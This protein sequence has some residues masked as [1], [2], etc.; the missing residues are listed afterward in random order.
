GCHSIYCAASEG[1]EEVVNLI[2]KFGGNPQLPRVGTDCTAAK[3]ARENGYSDLANR[4]ASKMKLDTRDRPES[5]LVCAV[6]ARDPL[7]VTLA[8]Q[9]LEA[10]PNATCSW[11]TYKAVPVLSYAVVHKATNVV[12]AL[13]KAEA[14]IVDWPGDVNCTGGEPPL[15]QAA[16]YGHLEICHLLLQHGANPN[17]T[18]SDGCHSI[19]AAASEGHRG[20]I[21]LIIDFGG[22]PQLSVD[23]FTAAVK[24]SQKGYREM[25]DWLVYQRK[26]PRREP[27]V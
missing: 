9:Q 27:K 22:D 19:Y 8:L 24:A 2:Y 4:L 23:G 3:V 17:V 14:I 26:L 15:V 13:L 6:K 20:V 25:A 5:E 7:R 11:D 21:K 12:K 10:N 1:N 18:N 16:L